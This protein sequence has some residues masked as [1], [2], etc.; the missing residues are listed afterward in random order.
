MSSEPTDLP[1]M[2]EKIGDP[3]QLRL[4]DF[5]AMTTLFA[6]LV[7]LFTPLARQIRTE[8][9][10]PLLAVLLGQAILI[11]LVML[12]EAKRRRSLLNGSGRR[13]GIGFAGEMEWRHWPLF[14]SAM[15]MMLIAALQV[16]FAVAV[17]RQPGIALLSP[18]FFLQQLQLGWLFGV[19]CSRYLW[20]VF[21]NSM[22]FFENGIAE[23]GTTLIPW[24]RISVRDSKFFRDRIVVVIRTTPGALDGDTTVVQVS[25]SLRSQITTL[26]GQRT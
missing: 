21:P 25:D 2:D 15:A 22:E 3:L 10:W 6:L 1:R 11:S 18:G 12:I 7:A 23:R 20:R 17:S 5:F 4:I 13:I 14:L 24:E 8:Q 19:A 16:L 9:R 26:F